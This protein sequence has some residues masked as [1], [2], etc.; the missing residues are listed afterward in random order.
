MRLDLRRDDAQH[1]ADGAALLK[2]VDAEPA[3]AGHAVGQVD[4]LGVLELL[5]VDLRHDRRAHGDDVFVVEAL[6]LR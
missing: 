3:Q 5:G 4:F 2:D 1:E 6:V